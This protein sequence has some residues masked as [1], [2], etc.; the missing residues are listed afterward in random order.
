[1]GPADLGDF[2]TLT[3]RDP[4]VNVFPE[5]RGRV[6]RLDPSWLGG[7]VWGRFESGRLVA[8][9]HLANNLVPIG[10]DPEAA[11]EFAERALERRHP[12]STLVGPQ[13]AVSAFFEVV[14][15]VWRQAR[16]E[17]WEQPH[18]ELSGPPRIDPDPLVTV[19]SPRDLALLYPACVAMYTEEVGVSPE[20]G[21]AA[22]LYYA[23]VRQLIQ[24]QW[25]FSRIEDG[26]VVFKAEVSC[27]TPYAAQI[28]GVYVAPERRGEGIAAPA[29]AAVVRRVQRFVAPVVSLYVNDWNLPARA[30]YERVGFR[31]TA[32]FATILY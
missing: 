10:A 9:C 24:R 15:P 32:R 6:T 31:E 13:A 28:Q 19:T 29:M 26:R 5:Y 16:H 23:R 21:G 25:S 27:A 8:A 14:A 12:V 22:D 7:E 17:R 1:M 3:G 30:A 4:V 11:R 18:L 2:L 20:A